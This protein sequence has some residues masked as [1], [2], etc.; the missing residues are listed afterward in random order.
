VE[1]NIERG[2]IFYRTQ[3][4]K[5]KGKN[6]CKMNLVRAPLTYLWKELLQLGDKIVDLI[7]GD[8]P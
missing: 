3:K 2:R 8:I 7:I 5:K 4:K 6:V 1:L